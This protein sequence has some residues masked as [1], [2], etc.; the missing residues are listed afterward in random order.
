MF[1]IDLAAMPHWADA[2]QGL[3]TVAAALISL[4]GFVFVIRQLRY[5][6]QAI[7][8][9]TQAQ[10]YSMGL[11]AYK[12]MIEHPELG[13]YFYDNAPLPQSGTERHKACSVFELFCDYFEYIILQK[14]AVSEDVR[15]SWMR[16]MEHLFQSSVAM[17]EFVAGRKHQ[18]TPQ[19]LAV[20]ERS[21]GKQPR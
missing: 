13:R 6:R 7:E 1:K 16:Y 2:F 20:Y 10:I 4:L 9:Q 21:I 12:I 5:T 11:E 18:Y 14:G 17:R 19:F 8:T 3:G 15:A